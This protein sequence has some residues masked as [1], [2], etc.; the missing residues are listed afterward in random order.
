[1]STADRVTRAGGESRSDRTHRNLY[2]HLSLLHG[3]WS[4]GVEALCGEEHLTEAH[5][6]VLWVLCLTDKSDGL[7][8]G[9]IADGL[10]N[11]A[12]DLTRLVDKLVRQGLVSRKPDP[13]DGRRMIVKPTAAGRRVFGRLTLLIKGLHVDQMA[14]LTERE[15]SDLVTLLNKALWGGAP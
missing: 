9:E 11:R 5:Y 14:G 13:Q 1:M 8:M 4:A 6:R 7:A 2:I 3:A 12:S 15:K 10:V